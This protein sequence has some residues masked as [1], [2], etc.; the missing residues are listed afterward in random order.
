MK[1]NTLSFPI[2]IPVFVMKYTSIT[3]SLGGIGQERGIKFEFVE[4]KTDV[5]IAA[6][7]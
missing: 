4:E 7:S 2:I 3:I 6:S 5:Q 1:L